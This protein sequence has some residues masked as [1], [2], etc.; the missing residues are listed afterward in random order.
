MTRISS[1][2]HLLWRNQKSVTSIEYA[3]I[4]FLIAVAILGAVAAL[5][6]SVFDLWTLI[7]DC[8]NDPGSC[9]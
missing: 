2:V 5:G 9:T 4:A 3:L 1:K 6:I 8:V 7:A